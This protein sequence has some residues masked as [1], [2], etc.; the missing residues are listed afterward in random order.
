MS[1]YQML[2]HIAVAAL[3]VMAWFCAYESVRADCSA[4]TDINS[5]QI[6]QNFSANCSSGEFDATVD[7]TVGGS[8]G[9]LEGVMVGDNSGGGRTST[10]FY[11]FGYN[12][13]GYVVCSFS[14]QNYQPRDGSGPA[15]EPVQLAPCSTWLHRIEV[16][17]VQGPS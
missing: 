3:S 11:G 1:K 2:R 13:A 10:I 12:D 6:G 16:Y 5:P 8:P 9:S 14:T 7:Y 17:I 15:G 4:S